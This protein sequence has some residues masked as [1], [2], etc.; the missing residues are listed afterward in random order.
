MPL[1][2]TCNKQLDEHGFAVVLIITAIGGVFYVMCVCVWSKH[3]K[4][5]NISV[6]DQTRYTQRQRNSR[7][8]DRCWGWGR[9]G[10][11]VDMHSYIYKLSRI[12]ANTARWCQFSWLKPLKIEYVLHHMLMHAYKNTYNTHMSTCIC[13]SIRPI[14][15][16]DNNGLLSKSIYIL[17]ARNLDVVRM[18]KCAI[19]FLFYLHIF[20]LFKKSWADLF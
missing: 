2:Q 5:F 12:G 15:Y 14:E 8:Y 17:C 19:I 1:E 6:A 11:V 10:G 16:R 3:R 13:L 4:C 9:G 18:S 20:V 7:D